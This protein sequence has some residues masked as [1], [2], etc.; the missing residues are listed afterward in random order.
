LIELQTKMFI[1]DEVKCLKDLHIRSENIFFI[2]DKC[3]MESNK[4][5]NYIEKVKCE[6]DLQIKRNN[7]KSKTKESNSEMFNLSN[8]LIQTLELLTQVENMI[9][10]TSKEV[11]EMSDI[12]IAKNSFAEFPEVIKHKREGHEGREGRKKSIK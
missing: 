8:N 12:L 10:S 1:E 2:N 6:V 7:I 5:K 4:L 11:G 3:L 9:N